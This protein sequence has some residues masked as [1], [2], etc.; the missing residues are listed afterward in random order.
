MGFGDV[1]AFEVTKNDQKHRYRANENE[2]VLNMQPLVSSALTHSLHR[3]CPTVQH[4][5]VAT[6]AMQLG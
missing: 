6:A 1:C 4:L 3:V 2:L 5:S